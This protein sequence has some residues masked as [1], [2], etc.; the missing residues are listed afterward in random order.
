MTSAAT[1]QDQAVLQG[2][3]L[4]RRICALLRESRVSLSVSDLQGCLI[5]QGVLISA[6]S[7][8]E[9]C[10]DLEQCG[11]LDRRPAAFLR[12]RWA[13][14]TMPLA[15]TLQTSI[16]PF[17]ASRH[18]CAVR[19]DAAHSEPPRVPFGRV[20]SVFHLGQAMLEFDHPLVDK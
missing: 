13:G 11:L 2:G 1:E 3:D 6:R 5:K 12:F 16:V 4:A 18:C 20:P 7:L 9:L 10:L 8:R 17:R 19:D 15:S 14:D